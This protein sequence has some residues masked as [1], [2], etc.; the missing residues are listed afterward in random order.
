M[1]SDMGLLRSL[2]GRTGA[3]HDVA[4]AAQ[5]EAARAEYGSAFVSQVP[6]IPD[7]LTVRRYDH[8][9]KLGAETVGCL[10]LLSAGLTAVGQDEVRLTLRADRLGDDDVRDAMKFFRTL[11]SQAAE[12]RTV[13]AY[14]RTIFRE[15]HLGFRAVVY[16]HA[17]LLDG[18]STPG[19]A[20]AAIAFK[21]S[22]VDA[23]QRGTTLRSL[24]RLGRISHHFP[25]PEVCDRT[26]AAT[27][28]DI[29]G[30]P[31]ML[32]RLVCIG[33]LGSW[34]TLRN[35]RVTLS[36]RPST[37]PQLA[38]WIAKIPGDQPFALLPGLDPTAR[39]CLVWCPGESGRRAITAQVALAPGEQVSLEIGGDLITAGCHCMFV[40]GQSDTGAMMVEDGFAVFLSDL[41]ARAL[42]HALER[43][44]PLEIPATEKRWPF[45]LEWREDAYYN[46]VDGGTYTTDWYVANP[47]GAPQ[48]RGRLHTSLRLLTPDIEIAARTTV[49]NGAR[50]VK[51]AEAR[52]AAVLEA[53]P[54]ACDLVV[55]FDCR[56]ESHEVRIAHR[57]GVPASVLTQLQ[58]ELGWV[59][60]LAPVGGP[61]SLQLEIHV[62]AQG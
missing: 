12:G 15:D 33:T 19:G 16:A 60:T 47:Q 54:G 2:F 40:P 49:E 39:T 50:F 34:V 46:P 51:A 10:T 20:L 44:E 8:H 17:R 23:L 35:D 43:G 31:S 30:E 4:A 59:P 22:E 5:L 27:C 28:P 9:A 62:D 42:R 6:L 7:Q 18:V 32:A 56:S 52:I 48:P 45:A 26:R 61:V 1:F 21:A 24:V 57:G 14:G 36:V 25:W 3:P 29:G 11:H 58:A 55:Q 53:F 13:S 38:E 37:G 41:D